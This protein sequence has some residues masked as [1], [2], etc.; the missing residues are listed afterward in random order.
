MSPAL[1]RTTPASPSA[2]GIRP[3]G[4]LPAIQEH[5][6]L[7]CVS[8]MSQGVSTIFEM[9]TRGP[10]AFRFSGSSHHIRLRCQPGTTCHPPVG[11]D[12]VCA[13]IHRSHLVLFL[14]KQPLSTRG[15]LLNGCE[16]VTDKVYC[17]SRTDPRSLVIPAFLA[18][19]LRP[20]QALYSPDPPGGRPTGLRLS[21]KASLSFRRGYTAAERNHHGVPHP[22]EALV[23][24]MRLT[25]RTCRELQQLEWEPEG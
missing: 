1:H 8:P 4:I 13:S 25:V 7:I 3:D 20:V 12:G 2:C 17:E 23:K 21:P 5:S 22:P 11:K 10:L 14:L 18:G 16:M 6:Q 15:G 24:A 9:P 19:K